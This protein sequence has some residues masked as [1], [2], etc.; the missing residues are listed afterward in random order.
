MRPALASLLVIVSIQLAFAQNST[1][2]LPPL[3]KDPRAMLTVASSLYAFNEPAQK[4]FHVKGEYQ[5]FDLNGKPGEQGSYEYWWIAPNTFRS[6]WTRRSGTDS[7]WHLGDGRRISVLS[8]DRLLFLEREIQDLLFSPVPDLAKLDAEHEVDRD[9]LEVGKQKFP[10][11]RVSKKKYAHVDYLIPGTGQDMYCFDPASP[12]LRVERFSEAVY[13][14]FSKLYM[15]EHRV[16]AKEI[17]VTTGRQTLLKFNVESITQFVKDDEAMTPPSNAMQSSSVSEP[18]SA[19]EGT[20]LKKDFPMYPRAAKESRISGIVLLDTVIG[21]DGKVKD[22]RVLAT[23]SPMLT[24]ASTE[25]VKG[26]QYKPYVLDGRPQEVGTMITI[27]FFLG[28]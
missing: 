8:G 28:R 22:V 15:L 17:T 26:W 7:E 14:E 20:L 6:S 16:F 13:V 18:Q 9:E 19:A 5:L 1:T 4:P 10:C 24:E 21:T 25:C 27:I 2:Q 3:P 11:V 23:P 12:V